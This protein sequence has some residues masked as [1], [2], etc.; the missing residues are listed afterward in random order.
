MRFENPITWF[1]DEFRR[2]NHEA[3]ERRAA[4]SSKLLAHP[5]LYAAGMTVFW[6]TLMW[7]ALGR[8]TDVA[9][10]VIL[11]IASVFY[12][13]S[14]FWWARRSNRKQRTVNAQGAANGR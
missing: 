8:D 7:L 12:G 13:L 14:M 3:R 1:R 10:L 11:A 9:W 4:R 6:G 5:V 2:E